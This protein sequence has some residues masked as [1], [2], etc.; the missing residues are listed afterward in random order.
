MC[1]TMFNPITGICGPSL[2]SVA[3]RVGA[4]PGC[5][6]VIVGTGLA[7]GGTMACV[8]YC[9]PD[10]PGIEAFGLALAAGLISVPFQVVAWL[11]MEDRS[12][13]MGLCAML[14]IAG[15]AIAAVGGRAVRTRSPRRVVERMAG[16]DV[17]AAVD[18][19]KAA[20][21]LGYGRWAHLALSPEGDRWVLPLHPYRKR[22]PLASPAARGA[23]EWWQ[24]RSMPRP[25]LYLHRVT[26]QQGE[27]EVLIETHVLWISEAMDQAYW[28]VLYPG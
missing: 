1:R 15:A 26:E 2:R 3:A 24:P 27:E 6:R 21:T 11:V 8:A 28:A 14:L 18:V 9:V 25:Q 10:V 23:P 7:M 4:A 16:G 22:P 5:V 12:A 19:L 13:G 17:P 20:E